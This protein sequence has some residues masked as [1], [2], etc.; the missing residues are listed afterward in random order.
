VNNDVPI[1]P[2]DRER[3]EE[4]VAAFRQKIEF[5]YAMAY[6]QGQIDGAKETIEKIKATK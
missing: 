3:I 2:Q 1:S 6:M 4:A 5:L